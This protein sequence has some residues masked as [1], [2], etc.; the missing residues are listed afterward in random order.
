[1]MT[2]FPVLEGCACHIAD[3]TAV[4]LAGCGPPF[5]L[6]LGLVRKSRRG[7]GTEGRDGSRLENRVKI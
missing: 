2:T 6:E 5:H 4:R 7:G 3:F 1:M